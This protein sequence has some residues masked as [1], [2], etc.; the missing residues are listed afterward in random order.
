MVVRSGESIA[1][2]GI[3]VEG[4]GFIDE[5]MITGEAERVF[6][7]NGDEVTGGTIC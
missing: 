6:R 1:L 7:K 4:N 5:S 3:I 2:D